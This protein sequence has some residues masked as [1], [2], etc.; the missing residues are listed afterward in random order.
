MNMNI[1]RDVC[2]VGHPFAP[3]GMGEH[4]RCSFR[5]LRS[6]GLRPSLYD[7]YEM[8]EKSD[9]EILEFSPFL[10]RQLSPINIFHLNGDEVVQALERIGANFD[11]NAYNI[12]YPAWELSI[13]PEVWAEQL[14]RFNEIWAPS[15]FIAEGLRKAC[16]RP[17][18]LMPLACEIVLSSFLGRRYFDI[19]ESS[20]AFLFFF[21]FRSYATRKNPG[22]V[23]EA[24]KRLLAMRPAANSCLVI[25]TNGG[26]QFA[27]QLEELKRQLA[28]ANI[29]NVLLDDTMTDNEV[30]NL[31]RVC[32]CFVSLHRSEGFGRGVAEAMY[33]GK[34]VIA[35]GYSGNIDFMTR[36]SSRLIDFQLQ[37]VREGEY[38]HWQNQ[39]WANPDTVQASDAMIE[40]LDDPAAG[41][42][43]GRKASLQIRRELSL[44]AVGGR[45]RD[46]LDAISANAAQ[47]DQIELEEAK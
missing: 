34:P 40:F 25:K 3:I 24:F 20:Y 13:Y 23:I 32:D 17:V 45:Y 21:D 7:V 18:T 12:I 15:A 10:K 27:N 22:A 5:A 47:P 1:T 44:R 29:P 33:L 30:K 11:A 37:P 19:P 6:V 36:D 39:V 31:V 35:T 4:V 8:S 16:N 2:L 46:R 42:E 38:P 28:S 26:P 9:E 43:L 14:D 41:R